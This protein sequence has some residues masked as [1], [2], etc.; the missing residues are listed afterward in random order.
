MTLNSKILAIL[1]VTLLFGGIFA[2]SALGWW[3]TESTKEAARFTSGE[4]TGQA[5][6]ADIR[7]SYTFGDVE[8]NFGVPASLMVQAFAVQTDDPAAFQVKSLESLYLGSSQEV[9]TASVRL[10]V[11][12]YLGL[13]IDLSTDMYV[14]VAAAEI[15]RSRELSADQLAYLEAHIVNFTPGAAPALVVTPAPAESTPAPDAVQPTPTVHVEGGD[16]SQ[17]KGKT[18]FAD[19]LALGL[20]QAKI[21]EILGQPMP[22]APGMTVKDF[23]SQNGLSFETIKAGLQAAVDALP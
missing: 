23:C 1:V 8:R 14:P 15:L 2:S 11:A 21:E 16:P 10:F 12:F 19:L 5:N 18:T 6:P 20:T 13:P 4:F 22:A 3:Q 17:V 7:G 9:G